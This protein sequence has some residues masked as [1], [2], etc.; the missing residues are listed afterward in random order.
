MIRVAL[1]DDQAIIRAGLERILSP[2]DGF[3]IVA[4]Y[5]D[6]LQAVEE[7]PGCAPT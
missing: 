2:T 5:A 1:V 3:E 4:E 7:L 6:G